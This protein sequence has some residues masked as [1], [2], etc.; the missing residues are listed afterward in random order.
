MAIFGSKEK[1][2]DVTALIAKKNY[3]KAIEVLKAQLKTKRDDPRVRMQLGDVL[4]LAGKGK[5]AI[6]ILTSVADE[7][8]REGF[9]AKAVAVLKKIQKIDPSRRDVDMKL[10]SLIEEK[11]KQATVAVPTGASGFEIGMEEIG[12]AEIGFAAPGREPISEPVSAPAPPPAPRPAPRPAPPAAPPPRA[13]APVVARPVVRQPEPIPEPEPEPEP[14]F[15]A[16]PEPVAFMPEPV[17]EP[18]AGPDLGLEAESFD[19]GAEPGVEPEPVVE[20]APAPVVDR[21]LIID[22]GEPEIMVEPEAEATPAD[23]MS[24]GAF[25]DELQSLVDD[26]FGGL[27]L[28]GGD[29]FPGVTETPTPQGGAQIVV[30]PLFKDFSV[31]EMVAVIA[32]LNLLSFKRGDV[33]LKEGARGDSLYMLTSGSVKAFQKKAGKQVPIGELEEGAFFGEVSILTGKPRSAS[34]VA[35]TACELLELDRPTL[36][37][38]TQTHPHVMAVLREFAQQRMAKKA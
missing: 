22:E 35:T 2:E 8:A 30:S 27:G 18:E 1:E 36:D 13:P 15:Q 29:D 10:A 31:D 28:G 17:I 6:P 19:L 33:I 32:G 24:D 34:I 38:I 20:A 16:E 3:A 14:I 37:S 9:A 23:V 5:D 4:I 12:V 25:A 21:D 11:Q 7:Y 26:V